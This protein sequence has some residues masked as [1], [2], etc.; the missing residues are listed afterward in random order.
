MNKLAV[1]I[2]AAGEGTRMKSALPKVLH[3]LAGTPLVQWVLAAVRQLRPQTIHLVVGHKSAQVRAALANDKLRFVEQKEQHGSGH[4][5]KQAEKQL[6]NFRGDI[7]VLCAD[8]PLISFAALDGLRRAHQ[9]EKNAAT[10]LAAEFANPFGYGRLVRTAAGNVEKIVEEKDAT[11]AEKAIRE[12]NSGIY[13]FRSPLLW[14]ALAKVRP[15]NAKKEYYLTDV[16][17]ILNAMGEKTGAAS[18][19][20]SDEIM[21][22]NTRVELGT[23]EAIIRNRVNRE[24]MLNGVTIVDPATTYIQPGAVIGQDTVILPHT[25]IDAQTKVGARCL[26]GP[27]TSIA[28]SR[29]ADDTEIRCSQVTGAIIG[30]GVHVG[31]FAH[32]R[33]GT[34]LKAGSKVGNFSEVKKS[35]IEEG[36]KINHLSYIGDS[37]VGKKVNIGAGTI[38]CNYDGVKKHATVIGDRAFIGSNVN[39]V[40]PVTVGCDVLLAAG[41]TITDD[42]PANAL[43]IARARQV[44]KPGRKPTGTAE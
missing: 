36:S 43:A 44:N 23:A 12:I 33:P 9:V 32:L 42:V 5:L 3:P 2:L 11:P 10:V 35:V 13:F 31:P 6:K 1:V 20:C 27:S 28:D 8:T 39:L 41:S 30:D 34:V 38:T 4:A 29:I 19:A 22:V 40:A 21:G 7:L 37:L 14:K 26:L 24:H 25:M 17:A 15:N 18:L 16:I